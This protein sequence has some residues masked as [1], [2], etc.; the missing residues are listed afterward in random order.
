MKLFLKCHTDKTKQEITRV[1]KIYMKYSRILEKRGNMTNKGQLITANVD[2]PEGSLTEPILKEISETI[3]FECGNAANWDKVE[4]AKQNKLSTPAMLYGQLIAGPEARQMFE[5][6]RGLWGCEMK[7]LDLSPYGEGQLTVIKR[8]LPSNAKGFVAYFNKTPHGVSKRP[9]EGKAFGPNNIEISMRSG[10]T[11]QQKSHKQSA[12]INVPEGLYSDEQY[13][14]ELLSHTCKDRTVFQNYMRSL[15]DDTK[16]TG[17][18]KNIFDTN[19]G[20][21]WHSPVERVW[22]YC[23]VINVFRIANLSLKEGF[24]F[25]DHMKGLVDEEV[26]KNPPGTA[27][28]AAYGRLVSAVGKQNW[29]GVNDKDEL[30]KMIKGLKVSVVKSKVNLMG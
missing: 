1:L 2:V 11:S 30:L 16:Y 5:W 29:N 20:T 23:M 18:H 14:Y 27:E 10:D 13:A 19:L 21:F 15:S 6:G 12:K 22:L 17:L 24:E 26:G 3:L 28:D 8:F 7:H 4:S 9:I 25:T